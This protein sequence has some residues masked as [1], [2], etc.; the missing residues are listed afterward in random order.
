MYSLLTSGQY[1]LFAVILG[2]LII[3]LSFHEFGHAITAKYFGDDTA[4]KMGRISLNPMRHLDFGGTLLL[5]FVGFGYAKPVPTNPNKFNSKWADLF[6]SGAG[7]FMNF[8]LAVFAINTY[9][10]LIK[11]GTVSPDQKDVQFFVLYFTQINLLLMVF[12]LIPIGAL[13]G[14]Y[15]LPYFLPKS[16][17][18]PYLYYNA[19]YGNHIFM[20]LILASIM[21]VPVFREVLSI[22]QALIPWIIFINP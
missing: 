2:A 4:E 12:N 7:P 14:H 18:R 9:L 20:I 22:G 17:R 15:I 13:D 10:L 5:I 8:I 1:V 11:T 16:L 6:I 3:A 21:G 19:K